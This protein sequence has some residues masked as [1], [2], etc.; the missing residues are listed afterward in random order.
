[1]AFAVST[2]IGAVG[3]GLAAYGTYSN[4]QNQKAGAEANAAAA[5]KQGQINQLQVSNV[6]NQQGLADIQFEQSQFQNDTQRQVLGYQSQADE[7]RQQASQLDATRRRR[8]AIRQ[9][10]VAQSQSLTTA[11]NQGAASPGSTA[12]E[13][14]RADI[15]GQT[16]VNLLG[17]SQNLEIGQRLFAINKNITSQYLNTLDQN[18]SFR[19]RSRDL[20]TNTFNTQRQIYSLGGSISNDYATAATAQGNAALGAGLT[21][22]GTT[23]A[24]SYP[25]I[26]R[27]TNYFGSSSSSNSAG[28]DYGYTASTYGNGYT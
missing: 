17:I 6:D 23:V 26:N 15:S 12:L 20:Q 5:A 28:T 2:V 19:T 11:T 25:T 3:V 16:G 24:N 10:I 9:G 13:Q 8:E 14:S 18:D 22:L 4:A 1:M 7:L 21:S 27:I